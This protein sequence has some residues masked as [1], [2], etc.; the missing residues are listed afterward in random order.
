MRPYARRAA[1]L[2]AKGVKQ[3]K[4]HRMREQRRVRT[5]RESENAICEQKHRK[6]DRLREQRRVRMLRENK[7]SEKT[8]ICDRRARMRG[9]SEKVIDCENSGV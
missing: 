2:N 5:L 3:R 8:I 7:G 1:R 6:F 4:C 9:V